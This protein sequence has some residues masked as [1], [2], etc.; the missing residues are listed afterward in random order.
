M[1]ISATTAGE[2]ERLQTAAAWHAR[3][4]TGADAWEAFTLWLEADPRNRAAFDAVDA[5]ASEAVELLSLNRETT[6]P[7][8]PPAARR[9]STRAF[10]G[11]GGIAAAVLLTIVARPDIFQPDEHEIVATVA[12]ERRD[13]TLSD[14]STV[15]LNTNTRV[16]V[17]MSRGTRNVRLEKGEAL[18]EVAR[19]PAR[20]FHVA[21]GDR[22]VRV[23]GTAFNV[24]RHDGR[25]TVTVERGVVDVTSDGAR[26]NVRLGAGDQYAAREGV[27]AY[28]VAKIDPTIAA[29]WR[30]GRAVF[31]NA[32]L[33]EVASDLSRY[34]GRPIVVRD[35]DVAAMRFSGILKIEDQL[36][37]VKRLEALLPIVVAENGDEVR[38]ERE[39]PP[40]K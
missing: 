15:H 4:E 1:S 19:D 40:S 16:A 2:T 20:P 25:I 11:I 7:A 17:T 30:D 33:S 8:P 28:Q 39:A 6:V 38:L 9:F 36:T 5:A 14:G 23:V 26:T 10:L 34:Y 29:A 37:T 13:V 27:R 22:E 12:G 32:T 21:A 3:L 24:L 18:F 31:T 35:A